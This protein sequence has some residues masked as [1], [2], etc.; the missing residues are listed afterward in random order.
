MIQYIAK[1]GGRYTYTDDFINL[2]DLALSVTSLFIGGND[3]IVSGC[4]FSVQTSGK[5]NI[6][7]G[8]VWIDGKMRQF[9]GASEVAM[10]GGYYLLSTYTLQSVK[11]AES[12]TK[13]GRGIYSVRGQTSLPP[14]GEKY[15]YVT[16]DLAAPR[17]K[18][19]FFGRYSILSN[20]TSVKQ[21][22]YKNLNVVGNLS[23]T[24]NIDA[25][26]SYVL[27]NPTDSKVRSFTTEFS[28]SSLNLTQYYGQTIKNQIKFLDNGNIVF[29]VGTTKGLE[30]TNE[31]IIV[32]KIISENASELSA[33]IGVYGNKINRISGSSDSD[34][35]DINYDGASNS[36]ARFRN[37]NIYDG[38]RAVI[39]SFVG[40]G[41]SLRVMGTVFS[42]TSEANGLVLKNSTYGFSESSYTK[43]LLFTDRN[44]ANGGK[45]GYEIGSKDLSIYNPIGG[46]VV[47]NS[48]FKVT[49][50]ISEGGQLLS[51]KYVSL[52]VIEDL[53]RTKQDAMPGMGLSQE[54]FTTELKTK[55]DNI[56]DYATGGDID[57]AVEGAVMKAKN[58]SDVPNKAAART[59]LEVM[60]SSEASGAFLRK[61]ANL[62]DLAN[63]SEAVKN[64]GIALAGDSWVKDDTYSKSQV[65]NR[66]ESDARYLASAN[67]VAWTDCSRGALTGEFAVKAK[68][69]G[70]MVNVQGKLSTSSV[71]SGQVWFS[72][73]NNIPAP[74]YGAGGCAWSEGRTDAENNRAFNWICNPG[75]KNITCM[76]SDGA[77]VV[78]GI[79]FT[80]F[81]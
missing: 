43:L 37:F 6:S 11:Y 71:G 33:D 40:S 16:K 78:V 30:I 36:T 62:S 42:E 48:S 4:D 64:L 25:T 51:S 17:I 47:N 23:V 56:G 21:T 29:N 50:N 45:L 67:N 52:Q 70:D 53:R 8:Y 54:N 68:R 44:N 28:P 57:T 3:F 12:A 24:G 38:K 9:T 41:H 65:W 10:D 60:S 59:N 26:S 32:K 27:L 74:P 20:P 63:K 73:P 18:D 35:I 77:S 55:L 58:L 61:S 79:D 39:A 31:G 72:L 22:I 66:T 46:V 13:D 5:Y 81:L 14:A 80:Y 49:G 1:V 7:P 75:S 19:E 15:I 34:S 76:Q 2:Q 69:I